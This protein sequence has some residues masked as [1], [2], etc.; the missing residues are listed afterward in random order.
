MAGKLA[1]DNA[2][3]LQSSLG[4]APTE[5]EVYLAH[6]QGAGGA[7]A[8]IA[9]PSE[10][11]VSALANHAGLSLEDADRNIRVN[12]G[13]PNMT[14]GQFAA[15]WTG[16]FDGAAPVAGANSPVPFTKEQL[17]A[18]PFLAA[19]SVR[20]ALQD[21]PIQI[22]YAKQ[23]IGLMEGAISLERHQLPRKWRKF[24]KSP[25][26]TRKSSGMPSRSYR[27]TSPLIR[28]QWRWR[29]NLTAAWLSGP[30]RQHRTIEP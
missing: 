20:A 1:I 30:G 27:P 8:L 2:K 26:R 21:K 25:R 19:A 24:S 22:A 10:N 29:D 11:A 6:Q 17:D 16:K 18:N 4:R 13:N 7:A 15:K 28:P 9:H 3:Q 14:A 23:Q 12:G 5:G